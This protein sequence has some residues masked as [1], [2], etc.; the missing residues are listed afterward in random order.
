MKMIREFADKLERQYGT[1][2]PF[3]LCDYLNIEFFR[4]E[5]PETVRGLCFQKD[6]NCSIILISSSLD[7][8]ESRY[9]CAHELGHTLLHPGLNAQAMVDLTN[10]CVP[11]LEHE[12]DYF[13]ACLLIDPTIEEWCEMYE[14]L[15][16]KNI[17]CLAGLPQS[18]VN[19]WHE[20]A[21]RDGTG[22]R[23]KKF[24]AIC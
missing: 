9:C 13:A 6:D 15:T 5:L 14:P 19:L 24:E 23:R 11:K 7:E 21:E 1:S 16:L 12:A 2:S 4:S 3:E 20:T 10:L 8:N 18:V 17:A 22:I